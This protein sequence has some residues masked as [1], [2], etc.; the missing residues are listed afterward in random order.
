MERGWWFPSPHLPVLV[1]LLAVLEDVSPAVRLAP[2]ARPPF[3]KSASRVGVACLVSA[4][5][6]VAARLTRPLNQSQ[7]R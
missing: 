3:L 7:Q 4:T 2:H 5:T 6:E 1:Y